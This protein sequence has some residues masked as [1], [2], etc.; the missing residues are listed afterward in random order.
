MSIKK[1]VS[2]SI[3]SSTRDETTELHI[4]DDTI[5]LS[6]IGTD[7]D[8]HK[9]KALLSELDGKVDAIGLGG[10]NLSMYMGRK[11]VPI[12]ETRWLIKDVKQTPIADG[13][14]I[15]DAIERNLPKQLENVL[16]ESLK[17]KKVFLVSGVE[18]PYLIDA[19]LNQGC[20]M[21]YGDLAVGL[22]LPIKLQNR[23]FMNFLAYL[24]VPIISLMPVKWIYPTGKQ[25]EEIIKGP[26]TKFMSEADIITGD[27]HFIRRYLPD[28]LAGKIIVTNT[29]TKEDRELLKE[30]GPV[31]L[32]TTSPNINGRSFATNML[33][34]A[35]V[36]AIGKEPKDI[37]EDEYRDYAK[38]L[39]FT[40]S[41]E[42]LD[43]H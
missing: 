17:G 10:T 25:Q 38:K 32:F 23:N 5:Q 2:V 34:A 20:E 37:T 13:S 24:I 11:S 39:N 35:L 27:F 7:G 33:A 29:I 40:P 26:G 18:R 14:A 12:R 28:S 36:A 41:W 21:T 22:G 1:A 4:G 43:S 3:G 19:F 9:A 30:R 8:L 16:G 15:K 42:V 31:R 6:R